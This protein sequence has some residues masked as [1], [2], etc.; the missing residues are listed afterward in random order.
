MAEHRLLVR[1]LSACYDKMTVFNELNFSVGRGE[2]LSVMGVSGCGKSTLLRVLSGFLEPA[3][4]E[5][6]IDGRLVASGGGASVSASQRGVGLMFQNFALFPHMSVGEN[7]AFGIRKMNNASVRVAELLALVQMSGF[8]SRSIDTLSGGQRQR[9]ALVRALAP[10]PAVLL[11][12]EP[13]ANLDA[14]LRRPIAQ[15]LKSVLKHEGAAAVMV[16]HDG[17]EALSLADQVAILEVQ[18]EE[19]AHLTQIGTPEDVYWHPHS[20]TV[21][22]LT[23]RSIIMDA[24]A[25]GDSA[26]TSMGSIPIDRS[27]AGSIRIMIRPDT[28]RWQHGEGEPFEVEDVYFCGP[29]YAVVVRNGEHRFELL[30]VIEPP[31]VGMPLRFTLTRPAVVLDSNP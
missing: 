5:I 17:A 19:P 22:R 11:L 15:M 13:F 28:I 18:G 30:N 4:G 14:Q 3:A 23:G 24:T 6:E 20:E 2:L 29:G 1:N 9:V 27:C 7:V 12:D 8:E 31:A 26:N 16:T 21:A 25:Q 10:K